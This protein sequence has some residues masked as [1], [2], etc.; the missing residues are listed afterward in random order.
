[1]I[2]KIIQL[3]CCRDYYLRFPLEGLM[4]GVVKKMML[5]SYEITVFGFFLEQI[6]EWTVGKDIFMTLV[7]YVPDIIHVNEPS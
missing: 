2:K 5:N 4:R 1:M 6:E 7:D 3:L